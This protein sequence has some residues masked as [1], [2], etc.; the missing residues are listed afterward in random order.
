MLFQITLTRFIHL[1]S[2]ETLKVHCQAQC[3]MTKNAFD[4]PK[5]PKIRYYQ[6]LRKRKAQQGTKAMIV[7]KHNLPTVFT[8]LK[9]KVEI[10]MSHQLIYLKNEI[11]E[12]RY[13]QNAYQHVDKSL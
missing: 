9:N 6:V 5:S 7:E 11:R 3:Q 8:I 13:K 1:V 2:I 4:L 10:T 12:K